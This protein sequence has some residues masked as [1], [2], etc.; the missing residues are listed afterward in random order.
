MK[1]SKIARLYQKGST[2]GVS[3]AA[4]MVARWLYWNSGIYR[5]RW[6]M[7]PPL[8][9]PFFLD[10]LETTPEGRRYALRFLDEQHE[11]FK[12]IP[13]G[14]LR[15]KI[16]LGDPVFGRNFFHNRIWEAFESELFFRLLTPGMSVLD[17]GAHIGYYA[18]HSARRVGTRG[19][20]YAFE[21]APSNF[22]LLREN[23][24]LNHLQSIVTVE[25]L[26]V[27]D[28]SQMLTLQLSATNSGDHR[29]YATEASDDSMFNRNQ[30]R[31]SIPIR[32]ISIDEYLR[33]KNAPAIGAVKIDVQGAEMQVLQG[34]KKTLYA[35]PN[36]YLFFEYW[37][38]G[39]TANKT[40]ARAPLEFLTQDLGLSLFFVDTEAKCIRGVGVD[41]LVEWASK[42][43]PHLQVDLVAARAEPAKGW[44]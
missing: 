4:T 17:I 5:T 2:E 18:L 42:Q 16:D 6:H 25:N 19:H 15:F 24:R 22:A 29:I 28:Q 1:N 21:P 40:P 34:M 11:R 7:R 30:S 26:A 13:S 41:E 9:D 43:D 38:F 32:A 23:V 8:R 27:S 14:A 12:V 37:Y 33:E 44:A 35:N 39:L 20:V 10:P 36:I 3:G 31:E